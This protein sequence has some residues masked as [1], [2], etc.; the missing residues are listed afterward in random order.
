MGPSWAPC[1]MPLPFRGV[2]LHC[3]HTSRNFTQNT[4]S[5]AVTPITP[6]FPSRVGLCNCFAVVDFSD[7][8]NGPSKVL[9]VF[10]KIQSVVYFWVLKTPHTQHCIKTESESV[11][12]IKTNSAGSING[13]QRLSKN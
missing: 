6:F 1:Y 3:S 4:P 11:F 12:F 8:K 13:R 2:A 7:H 5:K 9:D 10:D